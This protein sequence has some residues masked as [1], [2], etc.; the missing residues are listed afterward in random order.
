MTLKKHQQKMMHWIRL[1]KNVSQ[2]KIADILGVTTQ[3]ISNIEAG[4]AGLSPR[5]WGKLANHFHLPIL[6][7]KNAWMYDQLDI[8][9]LK[10]G[11]VDK[12]VH[13]LG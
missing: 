6:K 11:I 12:P 7:F 4:K 5:Q 3:F 10:S 9:D 2:G 8:F 1:E 13:R